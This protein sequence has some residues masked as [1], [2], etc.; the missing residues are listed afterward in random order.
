MRATITDGSDHCDSVA[1]ILDSATMPQDEPEATP[2]HHDA[3]T[4][5]IWEV[6]LFQCKLLAEGIRDLFVSPISIIA[7]ILGLV[8][9]GEQPDVYFRR[10]QRFGRR[11]DL[12]LNVFG[13]RHRGQTADSMVRPLEE[14]V[15]AQT[16]P[17]G[18]FVRSVGHV[19]ELLDSVNRKAGENTDSED[20]R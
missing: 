20:P 12:W 6:V 16:R 8:A 14:K 13:H 7:V 3:R 10:L 5:L 11:S 2:P 4:R 18:R 17:G 1:P 15:L 19:N 9:G